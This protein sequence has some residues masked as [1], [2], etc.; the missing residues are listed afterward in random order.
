MQRQNKKDTHV[1][2]LDSPWLTWLT[3]SISPPSSIRVRSLGAYNPI[4][5]SLFILRR[6]GQ[7]QGRHP[8]R[9]L[10]SHLSHW[11]PCLIY[12]RLS[13]RSSSVPHLNFLSIPWCMEKTSLKVLRGV[14]RK[15]NMIALWRSV[16]YNLIISHHSKKHP[17]P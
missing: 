11:H 3:P 13:C 8:K 1:V 17:W 16:V 5:A 7:H 2:E 15:V 12:W 9:I 14:E 10:T 6:L 4:D